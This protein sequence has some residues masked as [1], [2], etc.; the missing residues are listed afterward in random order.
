MSNNRVTVMIN[1]MTNKS[2]TW[3][4]LVRVVGA[5]K[6]SIAAKA[7]RNALSIRAHKVFGVACDGF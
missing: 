6:V 2:G 1:S 3:S 7:G 4:N 5:V